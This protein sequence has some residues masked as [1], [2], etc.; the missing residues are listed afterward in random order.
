MRD[1][2]GGC[3]GEMAQGKEYLPIVIRYSYYSLNLCPSGLQ[4]A[5]LF[6]H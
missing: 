4:L 3:L 6:P 2:G 1:G 5:T